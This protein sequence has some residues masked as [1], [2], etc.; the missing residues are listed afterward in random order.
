MK[1]VASARLGKLGG[2]FV[3]PL[4]DGGAGARG[5]RITSERESGLSCGRER[6]RVENRDSAPTCLSRAHAVGPRMNLA[7]WSRSRMK[8]DGF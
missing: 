6:E 4:S 7:G 8:S 5:G 1:E 3:R 2:C